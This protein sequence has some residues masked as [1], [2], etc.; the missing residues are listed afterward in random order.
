MATVGEIYKLIQK[1][2]RSGQIWFNVYH[3]EV[4]QV[5][6]STGLGSEDL[7]DAFIQDVQPSI[8]ALIS[9]FVSVEDYEAQ[10]LTNP[11]DYM[12]TIPGSGNAGLV[13]GVDALPEQWVYTMKCFRPYPPLRNGYKRFGGVAESVVDGDSTAPA[14]ATARDNLAN[15][16][17]AD[18][19]STAGDYVFRPVIVPG[20]YEGGTTPPPWRANRW[21][22]ARMGTQRTRMP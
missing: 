12:V 14:F 4:N 13:A 2:E 16:L 18:I 21:R 1:W 9:G 20:E 22:F 7:I 15:A 8:L 10:S 5:I 11:V 17:G 3:Y 6:D 19:A